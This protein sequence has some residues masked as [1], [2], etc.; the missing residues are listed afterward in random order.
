MLL[1]IWELVN[2]LLVAGAAVFALYGY[3]TKTV[4]DRELVFLGFCILASICLGKN[5]SD[6]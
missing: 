4:G 6:A 5:R 3:L 1:L 2:R